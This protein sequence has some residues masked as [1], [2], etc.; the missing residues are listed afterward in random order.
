MISS[1]VVVSFKGLYFYMYLSFK[2]GYPPP[3]ELF[4]I[5]VV[6]LFLIQG[7][8]IWSTLSFFAGR[9]LDLFLLMLNPLMYIHRL[10][11]SLGEFEYY[12]LIVT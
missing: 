9:Q 11:G 4:L 2:N 1:E 8:Y 7:F 6:Q 5:K 10:S 3:Q 12:I